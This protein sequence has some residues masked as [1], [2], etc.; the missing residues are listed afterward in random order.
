MRILGEAEIP[1][2]NRLAGISADQR[3]CEKVWSSPSRATIYNLTS[4][5][6]D[7]DKL[8]GVCSY[9][10]FGSDLPHQP[11]ALNNGNLLFP[12]FPPEDN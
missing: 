1:E 4:E 7:T 9:V 2:L 6:S 5:F 3:L 12:P 8:N 10:Y 11:S